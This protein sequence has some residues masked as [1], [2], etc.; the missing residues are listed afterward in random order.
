V[1]CK[2]VDH[3]ELEDGNK[4]TIGQTTVL[5]FTFQDQLDEKFQKRLY[6]SSTR[7][8]LT[9]AYKKAHF[10]DQ[11]KS[12]LSYCDRHDANFCVV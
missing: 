5:K 11:M 7:D 12:E 1:E 8:R 2:E 6:E 9:N 3:V 10:M 4:I